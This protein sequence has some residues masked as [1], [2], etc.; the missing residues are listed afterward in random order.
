MHHH[1]SESQKLGQH[2]YHHGHSLSLTGIADLFDEKKEHNTWDWLDKDD[3]DAID[4][5]GN[6]IA[7]EKTD[8]DT[9]EPFDNYE[10]DYVD[11]FGDLM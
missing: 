2:K 5:H 3:P 8:F 10:E 4:E 7:S 6:W 11:P 9:Y 1:S